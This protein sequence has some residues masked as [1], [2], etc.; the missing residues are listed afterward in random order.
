MLLLLEGFRR[1]CLCT[2]ENK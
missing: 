2:E 1:G